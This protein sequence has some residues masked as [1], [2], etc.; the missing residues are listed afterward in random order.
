MA[1]WEDLF[2]THIIDK[3]LIS[4]IH[5]KLLEINKN[6]TKSLLKIKEKRAKTRR[7]S[8]HTHKKTW[9]DFPGGPVVKTLPSNTGDMGSIP[10]WGTKIPHA[11]GCG[12]KL[13]KKKDMKMAY[14]HTK[15]CSIH[16][17]YEQ[18]EL[19]LRWNIFSTY[20]ILKNFGSL[21]MRW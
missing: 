13:K 18:C 1:T 9:K 10:G 2:A 19:K 15:I 14:K 12:Q 4:L 6:K 21:T 5:E 17:W 7:G 20:Q 11:V 16:S 8:S 3:G